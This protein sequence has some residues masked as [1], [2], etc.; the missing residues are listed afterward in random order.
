[1]AKLELIK[2]ETDTKKTYKPT[3]SFVFKLTFNNQEHMSEDV[4]FEVLYFG[5]AY[6]ENHD[7]KIG[8]N[9]IGPLDA[10]KLCFELET[11]PID[12]TKI[13]IKT[14]FGLTTVLI[15][16]KFRGEQFIRIGYVV[17]VRYPGIESKQLLDSEE[18]DF[19]GEEDDFEGEEE[20]DENAD[21]EEI[22][23]EEDDIELMD[24]KELEEE[25]EYSQCCSN[26]NCSCENAAQC[27]QEGNSCCKENED[28]NSMAGNIEDM[29]ADA[30]M[31]NANRKPIPLVT[32]IVSGKDEFEYKD[33]TMYQSKIE[34]TFLDKPIIHVFDIEWDTCDK[35]QQA[36]Q[37]SESDDSCCEKRNDE[38]NSKK[39][40]IK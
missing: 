18:D 3:D 12:L 13:P 29:L 35:N 31:P 38:E 1:M 21:D 27:C 20:L 11:T 30:L 32:P 40:K 6:S 17:D 19:E 23:E 14:L 5:D 4:E 25:E 2:V 28:E 15:V 10:G 8:Y 22:S 16:G 9:V 39:Q 37:S 36:I 7:Q 24:D 34:M 26:E 33:N